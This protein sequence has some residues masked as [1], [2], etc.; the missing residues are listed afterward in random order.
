MLRFLPLAISSLATL[1]AIAPPS[2][3]A[4]PLFP[5]QPGVDVFF[6]GLESF[7]R[8]RTPQYSPYNPVIYRP[9]QQSQTYIIVP[10]PYP[11]RPV[12]YPPPYSPVYY[13]YYP[14]Y[15]FRC[16]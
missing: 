5:N 16:R 3:A 1:V 11:P 10:V 8:P 12:I 14:C 7:G 4:Y 15:P 9:P 6:P 13:P 2:R